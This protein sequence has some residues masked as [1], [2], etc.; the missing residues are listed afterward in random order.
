MSTQKS[1]QKRPPVV[2]V[3]GHVDHGKTT[4]LDYIRKANVAGKEAGGITQAVGA[5][6][7]EHNGERITFIDTPGHEAFTQMRSRGAKVADLAILVI[8]ADD[9]VKPQTK[10]AIEI[11]KEAKIPFVVAINKIDKNNADIERAKAD[12]AQHEVLLEGYG[13]NISFQPI[14]ALKGE[15]VGD[16]LDLLLLAAEMEEFTFD[17]SAQPRGFILEA[18]MDAKSG[19]I[20]TAV[21]KDGMLHAGDEIQAGRAR[22]KIKNLKNFLGE[23]VKEL[24]P[25]SPAIILGFST[26]PQIGDRFGAEDQEGVIQEGREIKT[27]DPEKAINLVLSA[28]V[29]GSLE[30]LK[31]CVLSLKIPEGK[32]INVL[33]ESVGNVSDGDVKLASSTKATIVAFNVKVSPAAERLAEVQGVDILQSKIIYKLLEELEEKFEKQ[34]GSK[35]TGKLEVL[36][37][38][39]DK[40]SQKQLVGGRVIEGLMKNKTKIEIERDKEIVSA[41]HVTNLQQ[42]KTE[43]S[44]V[45]EGKECGLMIKSP[46]LIK[47][48]DILI[49]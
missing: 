18:R 42:G 11:L 1:A 23:N 9:G 30:A 19:L 3:M 36:A 2:V 4:V 16:L 21:L 13:G 44:Q 26:L 31:A 43:T 32:E 29:S 20:V 35:A 22:A 34:H 38:F 28:D 8:A 12:L 5:Y 24:S 25:S 33:S 41:G 10:E 46:M 39:N 47:V 6:E 49:Q 45:E 17:P 40:N 48:G 14:S 27:V 37:V 15:G 7:I